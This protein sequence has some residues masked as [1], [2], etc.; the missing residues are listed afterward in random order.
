[1]SDAMAE[2]FTAALG[3]GAPWQVEQ[4]RFE[5][6]EIH[7][8]VICAAKRLPCPRCAAP[9]QP[10]HDRL[11]RDWQHLHFFQYRELIHAAVPRVR[12]S[13]CGAQG[14]SEVQ[15]VTVPWARERSGFTPLFE[16]M[17]VTL[18]GMSRM[19]VRQVGALLGVNDARL[20]R[21]LGALVDAAY[22]KTDMSGVKAVG[23]DEKHIGRDRVM[24]V[25]HERSGPLRGR[26]LHVSEGCKGANVGEF[27][28]ALREHGGD[29]D[30]IER[31]TMDMAKSYIAG[32]RDHLP[33]AQACFDP[34]HIIK[35]ANEAL[36][37]VRR[38]EVATEPA[39]KRTRF[40]WLKDPSN[41]TRKEVNR[42]GLR[43]RG[44]TTAR[45]WRLK[46]RLRD[47]LAWRHHRHVPVVMLM[48]Q[49]INWAR[50]SRLP[51]FKRLAATFK[52]H[53]DGIRNTLAHAN[54]NG[55]AESINADIMGAIARARGFRT[56]RNLRTIIYLL[57]GKLDL[58]TS[59]YRS[60]VL[61]AG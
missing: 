2:L 30:A 59:P 34:F 20:W 38:A 23:V 48:D 44:L 19:S 14:D 55:M 17:V 24:T 37:I 6:H 47:I 25:V 36:E 40:H 16:A 28:Q 52:V 26:V 11:Q 54:S 61:Q 4:V 35:L 8:D 53:I 1:M 46:E 22:A 15:H 42:H 43:H 56:F 32:I 49:W 9:D 33:N 60:P 13:A 7:F 41:W 45:A 50:R 12:C 39:L 29:P 51:A 31:C 3:L 10:I 18:A 5:A 21:S 27:A 57:K 58:P